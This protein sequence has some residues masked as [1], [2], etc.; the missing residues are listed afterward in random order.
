MS[1]SSSI[2]PRGSTVRSLC[3]LVICMG[4]LMLY[5]GVYVEQARLQCDHVP[6]S[7]DDFV[8]ASA[9]RDVINATSRRRARVGDESSE[10]DAASWDYNWDSYVLI[11]VKI[12]WR[13]VETI[14]LL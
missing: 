9:T 4:L 2:M 11:L 7:R 1:N 5:V 10:P 13:Y 3:L 12:C 6:R 8:V 14:V